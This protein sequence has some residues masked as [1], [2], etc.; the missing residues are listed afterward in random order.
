[1]IKN[2]V[3]GGSGFLGSHIVERLLKEGESVI[4]LDN[5]S[6][7]YEQNINEWERSKNFKLIRQDIIQ[8]F[9]INVD[10]IWHLASPASPI[11]YQKDPIQT[12]RTNFLGTYN[13]LELARKNN[14]KLIF[15]SS[16]EVYGSPNI[17][18]QT[19]SFNGSVKSTGIRSCYYE[20][21]R[22]AES[23]CFDYFRKH[24]VKISIARIFNTYGP[25]MHPLDGR[26]VINFIAQALKSK[27]LTLYGDGSQT[28]S[29]CYV[30][31]LIEGLFKLMESS[32]TGPINLGNPEEITIL[33]LAELI[34]KKI[35][36]SIDFLLKPLPKDDPKK[37]KPDIT[38]AKDILKWRP[39][40]NIDE[41][42]NKTIRY[43]KAKI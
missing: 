6:S 24:K 41:G 12:S 39:E 32:H 7:S 5:F 10:K 8:P 31:D 40:I 23:L 3:T 18:P 27:P 4:C 35:D 38:L 25:K 13:M 11:Q 36:P 22:I 20:G 2:L 37:R 42:L 9:K 21:K 30:D 14:A 1:M 43:Y 29:F 34:R 26:V 28:R 16:S 17:H 33:N 15:A 19:E